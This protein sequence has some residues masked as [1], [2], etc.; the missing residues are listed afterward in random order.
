MEDTY[1]ND[2]GVVYTY[3]GEDTKDSSGKP[4]TNKAGEPIQ[5]PAVQNYSYDFSNNSRLYLNKNKKSG[6][7]SW[8]FVLYNTSNKENYQSVTGV[9]RLSVQI[10]RKRRARSRFFR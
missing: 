2:S 6:A 9:S 4:Y 5:V 3:R 8:K 1:A 7:I 10:W